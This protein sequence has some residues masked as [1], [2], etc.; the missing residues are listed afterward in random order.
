MRFLRPGL[1]LLAGAAS[2]LAYAPFELFP[3]AFV[4]LALLFRLLDGARPAAGRGG[5]FRQGFGIGFA[6]GV[7]ALLAGVSWIYI[8][9]HRFG[10]MPMPLAGLAVLLFCAGMAVHA[11]LAGGLFAALRRGRP[12][13][14]AA[15]FAATWLLGEWLRGW[16]FTGFPWLVSGY[17]QT[18]PSPLAGYAPLVGVYGVGGLLAFGAALAAQAV[19]RRCGRPLAVLALLL[20]CGGALRLVA[21]TAPVGEPV[22][23]ALLQTNIEQSLKWRPEMLRHW[24]D[25]NLQM[26]RDNP[27]QIV[28]LP[29]TTIPLLADSL[30]EGYL[31]EVRRIAA[32]HGGDAILGTFTRDAAG[33]I[34]NAAISVGQAASG[35]Y[36]KQ[37]L[38]PF[39]EYSPPLFSWFYDLASI[40]MADQT[41]GP[42]VQAPM[43]LAGQKVA[44]NICYE[45]VFG[46]ELIRSLPEATLLLNISNLAW[47][48][49]SLAQ[50]QHL[51]IARLRALETGRPMLRSTNTG[52]TALVMPDGAV[53]AVLPAFERGALQVEVRGYAG[54]TPYARW[55][56][57][58]AVGLAAVLVLLGLGSARRRS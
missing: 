53:Q 14:D 29:E 8:A 51:Q 21:W 37:H 18:P 9:L 6:W 44:L 11:G 2:V 42:A 33:H 27:A 12:W 7:G 19:Q 4:A 3:L 39:G 13:L 16:M 58:P 17:S 22:R 55:G 56:N 45:D 49:D 50:P 1:A 41:R 23:V 48:G 31:E 43:L 57:W 24:L 34:Y 20:A 47:Y 5:A 15:L 40:P 46:E 35:H 30:P 25:I 26:L 28:V 38:V 52:M 54:M 36:A 10:G 32:G